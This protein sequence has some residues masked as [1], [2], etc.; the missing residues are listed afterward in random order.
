VYEDHGLI[1]N[2]DDVISISSAALSELLQAVLAKGADFRFKARGT[3]MTP[4]IRNGDIITITSVKKVEIGSIVAF[5]RPG[6][7]QLVVHR[8]VAKRKE[9]VYIMGDGSSDHTDDWVPIK[10]IIGHLVR[11]E[12]NGQD[13]HLGFGIEKF[14]IAF[15]SRLKLLTQLRIMLAKFR[16]TDRDQAG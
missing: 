5:S 10:N 13:I 15:L 9:E 4:F 8:V 14:G 3:S 16:H 7:G 12:R 1:S 2:Q 11:I 6:T